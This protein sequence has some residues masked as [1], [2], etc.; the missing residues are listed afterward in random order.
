MEQFEALMSSWT[1]VV[2]FQNLLFLCIRIHRKRCGWRSDEEMEVW[3]G[4]FPSILPHLLLLSF[5]LKVSL[6]VVTP[7]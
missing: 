3:K 7:L 6:A 1:P 2:T 4:P 5:P